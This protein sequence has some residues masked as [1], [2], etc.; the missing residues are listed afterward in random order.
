MGLLRLLPRPMLAPPREDRELVAAARTGDEAAFAELVRRHQGGVRR[1]AARIL[2][3][4][5]EGRDIAQAA[6]IRA[7]ENLAKYDPAWSFSTWL[8]RIASNLAIDV[9]RSRDSRDR[10]HQTHLR[11]VGES[12]TPRAPER[13]AESEVQRIFGEL[14]EC[15]TPA[16]R[17]AFVLRE[18]QGLSTAEVAGVVGCSEATVRNHV[19][20]ARAVLR[21]ELAARYP[22][23]LPRGGGR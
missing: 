20:Q 5:E 6:F 18:V 11:L 14:T 17:S 13:L 8:Y 22:E 9:L 16:Q 1:C 10:T 4:D 12:E 3:D 15:L 2:G 19:F 7:W 23:Y 21:R